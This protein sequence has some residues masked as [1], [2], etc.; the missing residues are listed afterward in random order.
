MADSGRQIAYPSVEQICEINKRMI[1]EYDGLFVG[2]DNIHAD[3]SLE[4]VLDA[5]ELPM[6]GQDRYPTLTEKAAA[7]A[8]HIITRHVFHDGNK[9]TA[10]HAMLMFLRANG[11][12][13][14]LDQTLAALLEGV[15]AGTCGE[16]AIQEWIRERVS[17]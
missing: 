9:R 11:V 15:A 16:A 1:D 8:Y 7:L 14:K 6:Y 17:E 3:G 4:Y 5:I 12:E 13:L 10:G 2:A